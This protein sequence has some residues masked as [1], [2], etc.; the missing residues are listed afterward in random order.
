MAFPANDVTIIFCWSCGVTA[1]VFELVSTS[2][3][4]W[5]GNSIEEKTIQT[6]GFEKYNGNTDKTDMQI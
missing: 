5:T 1:L 6:I 2:R 4:V 3:V